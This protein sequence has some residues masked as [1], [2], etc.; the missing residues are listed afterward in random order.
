VL[1]G[2]AGI[3]DEAARDKVKDVTDPMKN[4]RKVIDTAQGK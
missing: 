2:V 4:A 1:G 3:G